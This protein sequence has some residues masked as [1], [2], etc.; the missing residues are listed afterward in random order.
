[1]SLRRG[2]ASLDFADRPEP[3]RPEV[4]TADVFAGKLKSEVLRAR[5]LAKLGAA[6]EASDCLVDDMSL[7]S[8][9]LRTDMS[10]YLRKCWATQGTRTQKISR[11][12]SV[13][14]KPSHARA[15][16]ALK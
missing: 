9:K 14:E 6:F 12:Y 5:P 16:G 2:V 1:V 10:Y 3:A 11:V 8:E 7:K 15:G 13:E 4:G